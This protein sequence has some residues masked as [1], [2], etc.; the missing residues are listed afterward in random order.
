[1][2]DTAEIAVTIMAASV[3]AL[4]AL[5]RDLQTSAKKHYGQGIRNSAVPDRNFASRCSDSR[6]RKETLKDDSSDRE[7]LTTSHGQI[8]RVDEIEVEYNNVSDSGNYEMRPKK[9]MS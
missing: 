7:I 5:F 1:M 6:S 2:L 8:L 9:S 3:P 4:R